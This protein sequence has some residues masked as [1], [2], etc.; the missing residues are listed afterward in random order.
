MMCCAVFLAAGMSQAAVPS[1]PVLQHVPRSDWRNVKDG[2]NGGP[3]AVGDGKT[4]DT[5]ALQA[6]FDAIGNSSSPA[7]FNTAYLPPGKYVVKQ[8]LKLYKVLG[9]TIIGHGESTVLVWQGQKGANSTMILSD[10][11]SRSR[12]M[13]FVLDGS[14]GCD[15][16]VE[17]HSNNSFFE[18]R[19]RHQNQ[20]FLNFGQAGIRIGDGGNQPGRSESAEIIYENCIFDSCGNA[21]PGL[22]YKPMSATGCGALAILN[23]N[24]YD[25]VFDG[26]H[27]SSN[28][29][30]IYND[31]MANVYVRNCNFENSSKADIY[32]AASAGNSVRRSVSRGSAQ[33][34]A[35]PARDPG[36]SN[37]TVIHDNRVDGWTSSAGAITYSLRGPVVAFDNQ[38]TNGPAG[39]VPIQPVPPEDTKYVFWVLTNNLLDG[40]AAGAAEIIKA[41][42]NM[43]VY[44]LDTIAPAKP[45]VPASKIS[46]TTSFLKSEWPVPAKIFDVSTFGA[47]GTD[48]NDDTAAFKAAIAA[49]AAAGNGALVYVPTGGYQI[50][51]PIQISGA[52]FGLGGT[53]YGS[54]IQLGCKMGSACPAAIV[55]SKVSNVF[56]EQIHLKT[57]TGVDRLLVQGGSGIHGFKMDGIYADN[58]ATNTQTWNETGTLHIEGLATGETVHAVHLDTNVNVSNSDAGTV[59][60]GMMI[61]SSLHVN[62]AS[63]GAARAPDSPPPLGFLTF[64]GLVDNYDVIIEDDAS[65]V[66]EDL[67]CEQLQTGHLML[68]GSGK[69]GS[70]G[71]RVTI[72]G[73]KSHVMSPAYAVINNYHGSLFYMSSFFME[74]GFPQWEF[75]QTG[76]AQFNLTLLGNNFDG[77]TLDS[78]QL[79]MGAG[80]KAGSLNLIANSASNF[81]DINCGDTM[82]PTLV[83]KISDPGYS[84]VHEAFDDFRRLGVADLMMNHPSV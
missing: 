63:S 82:A 20:K 35:A 41:T 54:V 3:K 49:A 27:F 64:I 9:G 2:C 40:K 47:N 71:G 12:M 57:P 61:Q 18:T 60:V 30:G 46:A 78:V 67:Y 74:K 17:H 10:G 59:L 58:S 29:Y 83:D 15:V 50:S 28:S 21:C 34:I 55:V 42:D 73:V 4:D 7:A 66:L 33:F 31:K 16:G 81:S 22:P 62:G 76:S 32:L 80:G 14:A 77:T 79:N 11:M 24:D 25:N 65:V 70:R 72:Q 39:V 69:G 51:E 56:V 13:G 6:C 84:L 19:L 23:F 8:T 37:P 53:G 44:D 43:K 68:S 75:T 52:N 26:C 45:A 5:A 36:V 48:H 1:L 38:F